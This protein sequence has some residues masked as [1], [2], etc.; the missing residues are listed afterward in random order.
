MGLLLFVLATTTSSYLEFSDPKNIALLVVSLA[1]LGAFPLWMNYQVR[2][3]RPAIIPN[4][5]WHNAAFT[6]TCIAVFFCWAAVN[7]IEYF[8]TL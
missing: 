6:A 8:T 2:R 4:K 7:A 5:L 1:L 3:G